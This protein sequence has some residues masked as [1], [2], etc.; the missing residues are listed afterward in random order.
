[1]K[2]LTAD[3]AEAIK[4]QPLTASRTRNL[5]VRVWGRDSSVP[6]GVPKLPNEV[7]WGEFSCLSALV[8]AWDCVTSRQFGY[9]G[10]RCSIHL[11]YGA[12]MTKPHYLMSINGDYF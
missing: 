3:Y 5:L 12:T 10:N 6:N 8:S 7:R 2:G 1:M 9:L 4:R 11:S